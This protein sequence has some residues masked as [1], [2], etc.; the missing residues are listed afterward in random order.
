M[1]YNAETGSGPDRKK[2]TRAGF[3]YGFGAYGLWGLLPL[4]FVLLLP[5]TAYEIVSMRVLFSV[6]FCLILLALTRSLGTL[7]QLFRD[8]KAVIALVIAGVLIATNW[9]L[10]V[11]ATTTGHT[12]EASLGY[13]INPIVA[14][15]L[16]VIVLREKLRPLQ[17][18]AIAVG[19]LAVLIMSVVYGSVPWLSLAL[20]FS[21]GFYGLVKSTI[22]GRYP[23]LVTLTGETAAIAPLALA[24]VFFLNSDGQ[25][26]L[27]SEGAGHF[28]LLASSGIITAVPLLLFGSAAARLPLS[29]VGM[30]QYVAPISQFILA[31]TVLNESMPLERWIGFGIVWC[32]V[33]LM[34]LD[35]VRAPRARRL[36]R[37][38]D[39]A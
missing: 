31:I 36:Q 35:A 25:I 9:L 16:G 2:R 30:I 4:Y 18:A 38:R 20:A 7:V 15:L 17:W 11:V 37:E 12:L 32:A 13:F 34:I 39:A 26:T 19:F 33:L 10:Y 8:G 14:V 28:W 23:A 27:F 22:G 1:T 29:T 21:F 6:L 3:L 24:A 5:A